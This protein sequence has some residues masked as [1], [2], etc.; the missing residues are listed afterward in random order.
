[1]NNDRVRWGIIGCGN[2]TEVKSGPGLQQAD[3]SELVAVMRRDGAKAQDYSQ[4][5]GVPRWYDDAQALIDDD[6]VDAVYIATP[7]DSHLEYT[8]RVAA[9][10]K[11]VYVEKPMARTAVECEQMV[12]ACAQAGVPLF[13]AYYRRRLPIHLQVESLLATG[14]IGT[15]LYVGIRH[16][17]VFGP[18]G[19]DDVP[20]RVVP[21]VAG[22]GGYFHDLASHQ[23]DLLDYLLG[24]VEPT[25][26]VALNL[27]GHYACDDT[28]TA[29]WRH[30][31]IAGVGSWC[32][33]AGDGLSAE[34]IEIVGSD[35]RLSF[36]AFSLDQPIRLQHADQIEEFAVPPPPHVQQPLIQSVVDDLLGRGTC[37]STGD[38]ALRTAKVMDHILGSV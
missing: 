19:D 34:E 26:G 30:G 3:G 1:L 28:V 13:V 38:S 35:G 24:P 6:G 18:G 33:V 8:R 11:P 17:G 36:T 16:V 27:G 22:K 2:V 31:D 5:H 10:G 21:E 32:F 7:P 12:Q 4:R 37:P 20:W 9:A 23:L 14:A 29:A 25:A 15:P